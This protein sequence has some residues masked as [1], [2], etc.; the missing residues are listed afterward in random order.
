MIC[1]ESVLFVRKICGEEIIC[2]VYV[3]VC[4]LF[5]SKSPTYMGSI[6]VVL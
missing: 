6:Y 2:S 5:Y 3:I 1:N 4:Y